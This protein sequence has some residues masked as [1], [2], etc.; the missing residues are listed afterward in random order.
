MEF[1]RRFLVI[2]SKVCSGG[3]NLDIYLKDFNNC[4][5]TY[6]IVVTR[7]L[8]GKFTEDMLKE[9]NLKPGM[10]CLDLG[11]GTGHA[12][13]IITRFVQPNGL[14]IGCD[15]SES[16]LEIARRK[17]SNSPIAKFVKQDMLSFLCGQRDNS[18]DLITA[19]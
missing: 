9:L 15:I 1:L 11:C 12:T 5:Y 14:V 17:L 8:L 16:M 13:E 10:R 4:A 6:D 3:H 18:A 2:I 7:K 19:F